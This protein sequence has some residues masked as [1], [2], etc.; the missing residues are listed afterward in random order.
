MAS[1]YSLFARILPLNVEELISAKYT[2]LHGEWLG[3]NTYHLDFLLLWIIY[4][5]VLKN[6]P[7]PSKP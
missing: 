6:Y 1:S 2:P 3:Q 5:V 7:F 4:V